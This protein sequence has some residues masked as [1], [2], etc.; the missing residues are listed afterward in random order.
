MRHYLHLTRTFIMTS[1]QQELAYRANFLVKLLNSLLNLGTGLLGVNIV[2]NQI[3]TVRGWSYASTLAVL[4]VYLVVSALHD[5]FIRPSLDA[6]VGMDGA[7]WRG[8][9]DFT[10]LRPINTQF[11]ASVH[12]WQLFS[13]ID[14]ALGV[15]VLGAATSRLTT[16]LTAAEV[17]AFLAALFGSMLVLYAIWLMFAS[18]VFWNPGFLFT[19][20]FNGIFQMARYPVGLYPGWLRLVLVWVIPVGMIT[21]T[22]ARALTGDLPLSLFAGS[23]LF[24]GTLVATASVLFRAGIRRYASASS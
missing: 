22:P 4:G 20:V 14:L 16:E 11:M 7:V 23:L 3:E 1:L 5:L 8:E 24:A 12:Q 9:F 17:V 2:F 18:L 13:L 19:W 15:M 6:L 21:T 10:L